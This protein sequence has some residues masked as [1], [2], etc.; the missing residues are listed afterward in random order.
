MPKMMAKRRFTQ[1]EMDTLYHEGELKNVSGFH[2]KDGSGTFT[3]D[4]TF[5]LVDGCKFH[6]KN[7]DAWK[8]CVGK[9]AAKA[10]RKKK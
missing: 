10:K 3:A 2:K 4:L 6:F 9:P 8:R 5:S 1:A 7:A